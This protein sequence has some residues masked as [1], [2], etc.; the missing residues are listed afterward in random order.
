MYRIVEQCLKI[1]TSEC[2][3]EF[4]IVTF[5]IKFVSNLH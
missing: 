4:G 5:N 1:Q 3:S 2:T